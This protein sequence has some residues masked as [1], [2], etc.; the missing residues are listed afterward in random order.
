MNDSYTW[1]QELKVSVHSKKKKK[2]HPK[3]TPQK[4]SIQNKNGQYSC[5][6]NQMSKYCINHNY[7]NQTNICKDMD[8][9]R[10][11]YT[12]PY[13]HEF[14]LIHTHT[15]T[16]TQTCIIISYTCRH[17]QVCTHTCIDVHTHTHTTTAIKKKKTIL[18]KSTTWTQTATTKT[19]PPLQRMCKICDKWQ[20]YFSSCSP[21][22]TWRK[23]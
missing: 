15:H 2:K 13:A 5:K 22:K 6:K 10:D 1:R 9:H 19:P 17:M 14:T 11:T 3:T 7:K 8:T 20:Q 4:T 12:Y 16:H 18:N 21:S 23:S